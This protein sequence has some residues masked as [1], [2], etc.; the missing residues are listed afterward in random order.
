MANRRAKLGANAGANVR[1][2]PKADA[3][4]V[5]GGG[6]DLAVL[7]TGNVGGCFLDLLHGQLSRVERELGVA[8]RLAV[9][10][11]SD[12]AAREPALRL[13][14]WR[15]ALAEG[16]PR[17]GLA[18]FTREMIGRRRAVV[19]DAT[20]CPRVA[21]WHAEWLRRGIAV[22]TANK[23]AAAASP[24]EYARLAAARARRGGYYH[25]TTVGAGLPALAAAGSLHRTGDRVDHVEAMLSGS[26]SWLLSQLDQPGA[27]FSALVE[28]ARWLGLTEPDP[29]EDLSGADVARKLVILARELGWPA[30]AADVTVQRLDTHYGPAA[31]AA[32]AEHAARARSRGQVLRYVADLSARGKAKVGLRELDAAHPFAHARAGDNVVVFRSR[33]YSAQPLVI[34]GP[35]A[36]AEVTAAG[37]LDAVWQLAERVRAPN[38]TGSTNGSTGWSA[39]TGRTSTAGAAD[40]LASAPN[41]VAPDC[42]AEN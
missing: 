10:A 37:L 16:G 19:I 12:R 23:L 32:W 40:G 42:R 38:A 15:Q 6:L 30:D 3:G 28:R 1:A 20:A 33:R 7:G 35:G 13:Q 14:A 17:P 9:V 41:F 21:A 31:D 22:V 4:I 11:R 39:V 25:E 24:P 27:G 2:N 29:A 26:L 36:G 34:Q 8:V 5:R 18:A